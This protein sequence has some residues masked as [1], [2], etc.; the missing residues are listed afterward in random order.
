[1]E[2]K[3]E[4]NAPLYPDFG[5]TKEIVEMRINRKGVEVGEKLE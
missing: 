1:M 3:E 2:S 5:Y 4:A